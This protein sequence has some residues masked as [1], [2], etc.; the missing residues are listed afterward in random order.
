MHSVLLQACSTAPSLQPLVAVTMNS[1]CCHTRQLCL[2]HL[3]SQPLVGFHC[4][5][6]C[7]CFRNRSVHAAAYQQPASTACR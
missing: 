5:C 2:V 6:V 1:E 7:R 4:Q 3:Q